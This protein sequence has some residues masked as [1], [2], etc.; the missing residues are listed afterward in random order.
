[1]RT[2]PLGLDRWFSRDTLALV[3]KDPCPVVVTDLLYFRD[4]SSARMHEPGGRSYTSFLRIEEGEP[5]AYQCTCP[6]RQSAADLCRHIALLYEESVELDADGAF[7]RLKS[8]RFET[9]LWFLV[10]KGMQTG[11]AGVRLEHD[12]EREGSIRIARASVD[13]E[14]R[15]ELHLESPDERTLTLAFAAWP[16]ESRPA[17]VAIE[18]S[19]D[20][21]ET[22]LMKETRTSQELALEKRGVA[23]TARQLW[24]SSFW[25]RVSRALFDLLG[26]ATDGARLERHE[27]GFALRHVSPAASL[28]FRLTHDAMA[29]LLQHPAA[30]A[31]LPRS[32]FRREE[33][34]AVPSLK[35]TLTPAGELRLTPAIVAGGQVFERHALDR[36]AFGRW[37]HFADA[38]L[39][40]TLT[41]APRLF[42]ERP[43]QS[44]AVLSFGGAWVPSSSGIPLERETTI[45]HDEVFAFLRRHGEAIASH[46]S[47]LVDAALREARPAEVDDLLRVEVIAAG[48]EEFELAVAWS[49]EGSPITLADVVS[50]KRKKQFVVMSGA[51]WVPTASPAFAWIDDLPKD[52]FAGRQAKSVRVRRVE[53]LRI[54]SSV[55]TLHITGDPEGAQ[56]LE[57]LA[58]LRSPSAAP[59]PAS[60]GIDLYAYQQT[61][62]QWLW[63]LDQQSFG[64][65]LCDDMGLGKTHQAMALM[66]GIV[67]GDARAR[68]LVCCPTSVIDHW[69]TKLAEYLPGIDAET[70]AGGTPGEAR[71]V[72]ASYGIARNHA[73][74]LSHIR[75]DLFVL[76]EIQMIKNRTTATHRALAGI[77][78]R[79]ALGLTGTPVE[80]HVGELRTLLDFVQ[81]GYLPGDASFE[82]QFAIPIERD[83]P[84]ARDRLARLVDP[85]VLRRTKAQVLPQLPEKI[86]DVRHCELTDEQKVLYREILLG[87]GKSVANDLESGR[88]VSYL[89]VFAV[90]NYLKQVCNHPALFHDDRDPES[91]ASGKWELFR[92][93][94]AESLDSGLKVVVFSQYVGM[95][96][97][98][99]KHLATIGI[100]FATIKGDT[101]DRGAMTRQFRDDPDCRVFTASLRAGGVGIDLTPASVVIHYDRWWN[102]AREDQAT[103]RVHRLGQNRG[104][105]VIKLI[106]KGT[107]E[108]KID[109]MIARKG[110]LAS[111]LVREDDPTLAKQFTRD[112]LKELLRDDLGE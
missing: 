28:R 13:G 97:L 59:D 32:G 42:P 45:P 4:G 8:E 64:G 74:A 106:T 15:F 18:A 101:K 21:R 19:R 112:Q 56:A 90:L 98:I 88:S 53:W 51:K 95:L 111:D 23:P 52:R 76:D 71:V 68:I 31:I 49:V 77:P 105:Q 34:A 46:P 48:E 30:A 80:N 44:Q 27:G 25:F 109:A 78:R 22:R 75:W 99:E 40:A 92:E 100:G 63:F 50:A 10:A 108:E 57:N 24:E 61:G 2:I 94:L 17:E 62:Y 54:R 66:R 102:Q 107:L 26:D 96:R 33:G 41:D 60:F 6:H 43:A 47:A 65:L 11:L 67:A 37:F 55:S 73:A 70:F 3:R 104:V 69:R 58:S 36:S 72:V 81:P 20:G 38:N 14:P 82:R 12:F 85:F 1:M 84:G 87:R 93:L 83:L 91:H 103:D 7:V 86:V 35:I 39:F 9:S 110:E 89:H 29:A 5:A 16:A 79:V